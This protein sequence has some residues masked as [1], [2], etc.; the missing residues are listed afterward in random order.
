M[1]IGVLANQ[2]RHLGGTLD[3]AAAEKGAWFVEWCDRMNL[4]LLVLAD[5]PGFLPGTGQEREGVIRYGAA[6]LRAFARATVPRVTVTL[7]QAFG[8]AHIVMNSRDLGADLTLAWSAARVGVMGARQAVEIV[9]RRELAAGAARMALE[10]AYEIEQLDVTVTAQGGFI[11][12]VIEPH[13][14]RERVAQALG[15]FV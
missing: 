2:P 7:R 13:E 3:V 9:G 10:T 12:E 6:F 15:A 1:P 11:D 14:T 8:G 5:T 4:P